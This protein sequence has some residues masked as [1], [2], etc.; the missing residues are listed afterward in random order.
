LAFSLEGVPRAVR[1][2]EIV[3]CLFEIRFDA[4]VFLDDLLRVLAVL[5]H[6]EFIDRLGVVRDGAEAVHGDRDRSHAEKTEGDQ[7]E[8]EDRGGELEGIGHQGHDRPALG[9]EIGNEH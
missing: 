7:A 2:F 4:E 1:R 6:G 5:D 9:D 3:F 8:G